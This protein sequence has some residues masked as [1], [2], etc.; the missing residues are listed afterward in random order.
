MQVS[1]D[2]EWVRSHDDAEALLRY[3]VPGARVTFHDRGSVL[4]LG[5]FREYVVTLDDEG[6]RVAHGPHT[7]GLPCKAGQMV[8]FV[9]RVASRED[10]TR[11]RP[12]A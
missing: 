3:A 5:A 10:L 4:R 1:Q 12:R 6:H 2:E 7:Y 9:K 11:V 8:A